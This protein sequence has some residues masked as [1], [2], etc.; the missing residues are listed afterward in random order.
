MRSLSSV[1]ERISSRAAIVGIAGLLF[2][3]GAAVLFGRQRP[4]L[5]DP[6]A[7]RSGARPRTALPR[8][9]LHILA[10]SGSPD[11]RNTALVRS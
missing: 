4:R 6:R 9:A 7:I 5:A 1:R 2:I 3:G 11:L 10:A 8:R